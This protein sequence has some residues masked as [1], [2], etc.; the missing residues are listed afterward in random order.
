MFHNYFKVGVFKVLL[1][2]V[3]LSLQ[4]IYP[5]PDLPPRGKE[6][7]NLSPLGENERG[8]KSKIERHLLLNF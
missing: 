3:S 7:Q 8:S 4:I 5:L 1:I 6:Y 2:D